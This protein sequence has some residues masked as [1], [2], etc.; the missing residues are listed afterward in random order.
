MADPAAARYGQG[1]LLLNK[2]RLGR[3]FFDEL[4]EPVVDL[5][6]HELGHE[7]ESNHLSDDYYRALTKLGARLAFAV[8]NDPTLLVL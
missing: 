6:I 4:N 7:Y 3:G 8:A 1:S 5:L 2:V